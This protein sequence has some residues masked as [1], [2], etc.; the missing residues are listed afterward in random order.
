MPKGET[1]QGTEWEV[2]GGQFKNWVGTS[3]A[4]QWLRIEPQGMQVQ[5]LVQEDPTCLGATEPLCHSY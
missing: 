5:S 3:L 2:L 4:V 1:K